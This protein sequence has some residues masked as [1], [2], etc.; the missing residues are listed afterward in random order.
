[1]L[2][3]NW[4]SQRVVARIAGLLYLAYIVI[5]ATSSFI[6]GRPIAWADAT[7]T[8]RAI[9]ASPEMFRLGVS[10]E[11]ISALLFL[12]TAWALYVLFKPVNADLALLFL[13]LNLVGV[14]IECVDTLLHFA[15]LFLSSGGP[16][17]AALRPEQLQSLGMIFLKVGGDG[18]MMC[19]LFY[20]AWLFPLGYLVV[21]SRL[22]PKVFGILLIIDG[23][24]LMIC[25]VQMWFFP[26]YKKLT[27]PLYPVMFV[28]E[29]GLA[30]WL[31]IKGVRD[32]I[33][34]P[35]LERALKR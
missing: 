21:R 19:A 10:L 13:L 11:L 35:A 34:T 8:A 3:P 2:N 1:M 27:Y 26:G 20:A 12:L 14:G 23:I 32:T 7:A 17:L 28:A 9:V 29:F 31:A 22:V 30:L 6:Q 25:F 16:A 4:L 5:F 24:S 18:G 15:A 33:S